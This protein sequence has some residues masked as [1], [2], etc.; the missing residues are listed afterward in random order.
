M[1]W[2]KNNHRLV[3]LS[4]LFDCQMAEPLTLVW[5]N[6]ALM[7]YMYPSK[8]ARKHKAVWVW[9][10]TVTQSL[11]VT[12]PIRERLDWEDG[13]CIQQSPQ[14]KWHSGTWAENNGGMDRWT[15]GGQK[16][17]VFVRDAETNGC[18][19]PKAVGEKSDS[20]SRDLEDF[21]DRLKAVW[22][23][24]GVMIAAVKAGGGGAEAQIGKWI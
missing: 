22:A 10:S 7:S 9:L 14:G 19:Y 21:S 15:N 17:K 18:L 5:M 12:Q 4:H 23:Q 16:N 20:S 13:T 6:N 3:K 11:A 24:G 2:P 8:S 1:F